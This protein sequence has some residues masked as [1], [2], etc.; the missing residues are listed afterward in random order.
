M[1]PAPVSPTSLVRRPRPVPREPVLLVTPPS[2]FLLDER[3][4][5]SLGI[6]KVGAVLKAAGFAVEHLDL[7]GIQNYE[8]AAEAHARATTAFAVCLTATTP[9]LPAATRIVA[10]L[11]TARPGLRVIL[12]G[13]HATLVCAAAKIERKAGRSGRAC[14]ALARL[15]GLFDV[16]VSGDGESAVFDA[17][18]EDAPKVVD[19][20]DP[21]GPHFMT[22][23]A[24]EESPWPARELVDVGS[25]HYEIEGHRAI[26][27]I[28]Q[29]GC[30]FK[31]GFCGGRSTSMLRRIRTRSTANV[32]AEIEHLHREYGVTGFNLFDDELNVN[33]EIV[34]LMDAI[35]ELQGRL[36]VE[37]RLR[38]FVKSELFTDEQAA[39]MRRAGFRW[40]LCGFEAASPRILV[41]I[42]KQATLDDNTRVVETCARHGLKVK[43]LMSVGHPGESEESILAV[44][45]WLLAV[46]PAAFDCTVISCFP[47]T[48][49]YDLATPH[50][51]VAGAWTYAHRKTGDRLHS[52]DVDFSTTADYYKG[53]PSG[54]YT[55]YVFTDHLSGPEIV[56]LRD[57]VEREVRETLGIPYDAGA[58]GVKYEHSMGQG[59]V[60]RLP[61][62]ILRSA[63]G[64]SGPRGPLTDG[65]RND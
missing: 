26:H 16:V 32:V 31:C 28:A 34:G 54:G 8:D 1:N 50:E 3:V 30:P 51:S 27:I 7:S 20:D 60:N 23:A 22:S 46:R 58:P 59:N 37:F 40:I 18:R 49:Y 57:Q 24:Y 6:L 14:A 43:A 38:G 64:L 9:Q 21:R 25:Y 15:E 33:K 48:P 4:F 17:L 41:N 53:D 56:R 35:T 65:P 5:M 29:L 42:D 63:A 10:R 12:G 62:H 19:A 55:S 13:P 2:I 11:R 52:V 47:G 45:D 39:A 44:R 61:R 36:G